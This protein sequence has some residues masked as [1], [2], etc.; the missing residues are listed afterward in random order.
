[1]KGSAYFVAAIWLA[2]ASNAVSAKA[3]LLQTVDL[4]GMS[5]EGGEA[6]LY[7]SKGPIRGLCSIKVVHY[8]EMGKTTYEFFFQR[9]LI[10]A[11]KLE[12]EYSAPIYEDPNFKSKLAK[13]TTLRSKLGR[14]TLRPDFEE[15]KALFQTNALAKCGSGARP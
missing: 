8:G 2:S 14:Q 11:I 9:H 1:M 10:D 3:H 13:T 15:Y 5:T 7:L 12:F 4:N 6:E